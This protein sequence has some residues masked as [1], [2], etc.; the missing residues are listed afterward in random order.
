MLTDYRQ[1]YGREW[2]TQASILP[3]E[4]YH[5]GLCGFAAS[6]ILYMSFVTWYLCFA[7]GTR[8]NATIPSRPV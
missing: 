1:Y 3:R 6:S 7:N 4:V 5:A 2:V 8:P